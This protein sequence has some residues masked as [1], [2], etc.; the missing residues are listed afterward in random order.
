VNYKT[1]SVTTGYTTVNAE[2][3]SP[4]LNANGAAEVIACGSDGLTEPWAALLRGYANDLATRNFTVIL[5][6][7][8]ARTATV[9]GVAVL[10]RIAACRNQWQAVPEDSVDCAKVMLGSARPESDR[11]A[12]RSVV[13]F[14]YGC[15]TPPVCRSNSSLQSSRRSTASGLPPPFCPTRKFITGWRTTSFHF[16]MPKPFTNDAAE[17]KMNEAGN[18]GLI[19]R[20]HADFTLFSNAVIV[21]ASESQ[22]VCNA[23]Y[24]MIGGDV[25]D[26]RHAPVGFSRHHYELKIHPRRERARQ[27]TAL[28][29]GRW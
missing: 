14:V 17:C 9:P 1:K 22:G 21:L 29:C 13:N 24:S 6:D 23:P 7:Y 5:P 2:V 3:Y 20:N 12:S 16:R 26:S 19:P 4:V 28:R 11:W 8:L 18:P 27:P 15:G 10:G 25:G